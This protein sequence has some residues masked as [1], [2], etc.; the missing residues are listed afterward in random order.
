MTLSDSLITISPITEVIPLPQ[1][2]ALEVDLVCLSGYHLRSYLTFVKE[3][4]P[5][6]S[7]RL[8]DIAGVNS[9]YA[10]RNISTGVDSFVLVSTQE[11]T[12]V[13]VPIKAG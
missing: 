13:L 8:R 3:F 6:D 9:V 12:M 5:T 2:S 10:I 4:M 1:A 11:A 7:M